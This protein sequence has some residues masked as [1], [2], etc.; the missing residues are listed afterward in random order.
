MLPAW[1]RSLC[2]G[3]RACQPP[4]RLA[5]PLKRGECCSPGPRE[6]RYAGRV[7]AAAGLLTCEHRRGGVLPHLPLV[8][9]LSSSLAVAQFPRLKVEMA[10]FLIGCNPSNTHQVP[11]AVCGDPEVSPQ[12]TLSPVPRGAEAGWAQAAGQA[13]PRPASLSPARGVGS[14]ASEPRACV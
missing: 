12:L 10:T 4:L 13:R 11:S 6:A 1:R 3:Q 2:L 5:F 8:P 9:S 7:C 14:T